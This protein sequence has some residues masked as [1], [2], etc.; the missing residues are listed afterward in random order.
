MILK[1]ELY[2]FLRWLTGVSIINAITFYLYKF[3]IKVFRKISLFKR[4]KYPIS[5]KKIIISNAVFNDTPILS[6][7]IL[8]SVGG[9]LK[10]HPKNIPLAGCLL[11]INAG[12]IDW[13]EELLDPEDEVSLHRW[14]WSIRLRS[15][16]NE[17]DMNALVSWV[18]LQQETWVD[19]FQ[20]ELFEEGTNGLLRWESYTVSERIS[21][22]VVFYHGSI[23]G[24]PSLKIKNALIE[25][26]LFLLKNLE[27]LGDKTGNHI[28]NNAR[29]IYLA[30]VAYGCHNW[31][32]IA[33]TIFE[34]ELPKLVTVDGFMRE[35]SSHYQFLFTRWL[36]EVY[37]FAS[38]EGDSRVMTFL[39]PI[40]KSL[41]DKCHF[42]LIYNEEKKNW[43]IPLFGDISPDFPPEWLLYLPWSQFASSFVVPPSPAP[44]NILDGW[45]RLWEDKKH[46]LNSVPS[47][48]KENNYNKKSSG[49]QSSGWFR[50]KYLDNTLLYRLDR[51]A[52]PNYV[53]HHHYD[54][55]HFCLFSKGIPLLVDAGRKNYSLSDPF[56]KFGLSPNAHNSILIDGVGV[57]PEKYWFYP[58]EYSQAR[59]I[60]SV[61]K[62][63]KSIVITIESTGFQRLSSPISL[64]RT[65]TLTDNSCE[66]EDCF[67]GE[68]T[69]QI[70][71]FFHFAFEGE[72]QSLYGNQLLFN[73]ESICGKFE[74]DEKNKLIL[75]HHNGGSS[76]L[77]WQVTKYGSSKPTSTLVF[78]G[79]VSLPLS[80]KYKLIWN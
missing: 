40:I 68:G 18:L 60:S 50:Y 53:G 33:T 17:Y 51:D 43:T 44:V 63:K 52:I 24:W 55:Y 19:K 41:I 13:E 5:V 45:N 7:V 6:S 75:E 29:A 20:C 39:A 79:E 23:N 62:N 3:S 36:L 56:G 72:I 49:Y 2:S 8:P 28:I 27:Y 14:N 47:T 25:Q 69:H 12:H 15:S 67:T 38:L 71:S 37:Y 70:T 64:I 80:Q 74:C 31:K 48:N 78:D 30:G 1:V 73:T 42:F 11:S 10:Y 57:V 21:N 76:P 35:G 16:V 77:G 9:D 54:I 66:I 58:N 32:Q 4:T 34:R 65:I 46:A 26:V 61:H 59:N 22:S